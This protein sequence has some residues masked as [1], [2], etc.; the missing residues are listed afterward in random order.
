MKHTITFLLLAVLVT[1]CASSHKS[2]GVPPGPSSRVRLT[3]A[4][5]LL[6][7]G[8]TTEATSMLASICAEPGVPG[9]TDEAL[10][11]FTLLRLGKET[12]KDEFPSARQALERL[13]QDYPASPWSRQAAP[14]LE[15]LVST[16]DMSR[17]NRNLKSLNLSLSQENERLTRESRELRETLEKLKHLDLELEGK[18]R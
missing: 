15:L 12:D 11:R 1:G 2:A 7:E 13:Q 10:F 5:R 3:V 8:D 18:G 9:V 16:S 4:V 17:T 6:E 14:L